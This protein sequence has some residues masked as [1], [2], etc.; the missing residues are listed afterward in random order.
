MP[1]P[2]RLE[3]AGAL[4]DVIACGK[5]RKPI[6]LDDEDRHSFF[7]GLSGACARFD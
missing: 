4:H 6:F 3:F 2:L 1:R 5:A 7:D